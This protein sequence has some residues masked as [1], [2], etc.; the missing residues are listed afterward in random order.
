VQSDGPPDAPGRVRLPRLDVPRPRELRRGDAIEPVGFGP[1]AASWPTRA[2]KLGSHAGRWSAARWWEQPF[3]EGFEPAFFNVAAVD[4]QVQK[5]SAD[6]RLELQNLHPEHPRLVMQLP[7]LR[8]KAMVSRSS[9]LDVREEI[10]LVC[11]TLWIDTDRSL[12]SLTW[13]GWVRLCDPL[14]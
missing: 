11:D 3:P 8:P 4:Q 10:R 9:A 13:R 7:G 1:I 14:E 5:L 2:E 12:C 6:E